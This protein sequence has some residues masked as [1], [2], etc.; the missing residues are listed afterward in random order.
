MRVNQ[1]A[2]FSQFH[3]VAL[4]KL[5]MSSLLVIVL[6]SPQLFYNRLMIMLCDVC[7]HCT[8]TCRIGE[9]TCQLS[10]TT[11]C[12]SA[13]LLFAKFLLLSKERQSPQ[14]KAF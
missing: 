1:L 2:Y 12:T 13:F 10:V 6:L 11:S 8:Q 5:G 14:Q 7:L 3:F 4:N 9:C